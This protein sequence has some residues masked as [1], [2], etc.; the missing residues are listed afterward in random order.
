MR[1][2]MTARWPRLFLTDAGMEALQVMT[3]KRPADP[4]Q[5]AHVRQEPRIGSG[6]DQA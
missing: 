4:V 2:D 3:D 5:F 6:H 1:L